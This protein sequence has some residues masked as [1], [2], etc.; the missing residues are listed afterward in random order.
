MAYALV[1][2][3]QC[4]SY[5]L[6][7]LFLLLNPLNT[8]SDHDR[9]DS[10]KRHPTII[11]KA[12]SIQSLRTTTRDLYILFNTKEKD[13]IYQIRGMVMHSSHNVKLAIFQG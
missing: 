3:R 12:M 6:P 8:H 11:S 10:Y 9:S 13:Q 4:L 7:L 2:Q 1:T 5:R